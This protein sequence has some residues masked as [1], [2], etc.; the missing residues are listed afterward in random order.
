V[1]V[2]FDTSAFVPIVIEESTSRVAARLWREADRVVSNRLLYAEARAALAMAHR[3][4]RIDDPGLRAAVKGVDD[5]V[6]EL[7]MVE[8]TDDLVRKAGAHA[9]ALA[10]RGY[11]A[12]HL[13]SAKLVD[14]GD[15]VL[16]SG[17]RDLV[18]AARSIGLGVADLHRDS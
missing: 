7:D 14:D 1:I 13:A 12:V 6:A 2:Y 16:A 11:D 15:L 9:E 4:K 17:D 18:K 8:V 5:L 10:L 3:M